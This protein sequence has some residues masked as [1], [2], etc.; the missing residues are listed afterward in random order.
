MLGRGDEHGKMR[1]TSDPEEKLKA[2][3]CFIGKTEQ[4]GGVGVGHTDRY[5]RKSR[6][7]EGPRARGVSV[8]EKYSSH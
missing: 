8:G 7:H 2:G 5:T 3:A 1:S 6:A 4:D